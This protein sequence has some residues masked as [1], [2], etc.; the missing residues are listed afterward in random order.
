MADPIHIKIEGL[1]KIHKA[2]AEFPRQ[3]GKYFAQAGAESAHE[4]LKEQ[5]LK[6]YPPATEANAPPTPYYIRGRGT[7]TAHGNLNNSERLG[8]QF[9][10]DS[11]VGGFKTE[12][13]NRASYAQYVIGEEQAGNMGIKGW[14]KLWD[15]AIEKRDKITD[16]YQ[17]WINKLIRD[18]GL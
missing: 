14:R 11:N 15:V 16:I 17:A 12:I 13:G 7:Q 1:D 8:T 5:G 10:I 3:I 2:L 18:L 4:I 9:Y 6:S